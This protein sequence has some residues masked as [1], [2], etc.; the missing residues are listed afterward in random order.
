VTDPGS[1]PRSGLRN[2]PAAVRGA[3]AGALAAMALVLLMAVVPFIRLDAPPEAII[4]AV[5]LAV[6]ALV[7]CALL[8]HAWAWYA[9]LLVPAVLLASTGWH[10]ALGVLGALF[11]LVW[12]YVLYVRRTVL[13]G[14]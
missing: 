14:R 6:A 3:G 2:P 5:V 13:G 9:A 12:A 7:L 11:A 1:V 10:P 8:R 4:V